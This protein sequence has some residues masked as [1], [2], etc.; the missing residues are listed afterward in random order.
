[1]HRVLPALA[2]SL[3]LA[4]T[5]AGCAGPGPRE[6]ELARLDEFERHAGPPV[7]DFHFWS[8]DRWESLGPDAVAIW[9]RV[10]EAWLIRVR[11]PCTGL[12]FASSI[13]VT[14][15][16]NRVYRAFDSVLF[17]RQRCRIAEIRPVD[18]KAMKA[19]RRARDASGG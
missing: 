2:A 10:N 9:T 5:L 16:N 11:Q 18:G 15:T 17:E 8:I 7:D 3:L 1:M 4:T 13:A 12:E 14:S 19:E 6:R